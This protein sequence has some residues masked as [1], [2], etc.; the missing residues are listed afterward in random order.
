MTTSDRKRTLFLYPHGLGD[1][2]LATAVL[3]AYKLK[4]GGHVGFV[5][6]ERFRS[7]E[8]LANCP[9]IDKL[10]FCKDMYHDFSSHAAGRR[11]LVKQYQNVARAESYD[12][13]EFLHTKNGHKILV[14]CSQLKLELDDPHTE[15]FITPEDEEAAKVWIP[16]EP[17][18][19]IQS[20]TGV[21]A[22]D[23][24]AGYGRKW[25]AKRKG[26][27]KTVEVGVD[28]AY[29]AININVQFAITRAASGVCVPDSVF[30]HACGALDKDVDFAYFSNGCSVYNRVKPLHPVTQNIAYELEQFPK[31]NGAES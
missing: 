20:S 31:Q 10:Y 6:L 27:T 18:G 4:V 13:F 3:K 30:Y 21:P 22:K 12:R 17:F 8:L 1:C 19:F 7:S 16:N 28:F 15:V 24:P 5:M 25:L 23:L 9:Y 26:L 14:S 29:D 11:A 2:I